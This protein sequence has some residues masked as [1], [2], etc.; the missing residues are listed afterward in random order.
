MRTLEISISIWRN[1]IRNMVGRQ[2]ELSGPCLQY[3]RQICSIRSERTLGELPRRLSWYCSLVRGLY[4]F[5]RLT[6]LD[7]YGNQKK[8]K[9]SKSY[10]I[11]GATNLIAIQDKIEYARFKKIF[12]LGFSDSANRGHEPKV[13]GTIDTFIKK[14]S[15]N[16]EKDGWTTSKNM[17]HWCITSHSNDSFQ[18]TTDSQ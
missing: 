14:I 16:E 12:Q 7:I 8:V 1:A 15:E 2:P 18:K 6:R 9:K 10:N 17:T 5:F 11:H 13:I 3:F 4:C